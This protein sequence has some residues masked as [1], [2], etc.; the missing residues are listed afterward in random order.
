MTR[1]GKRFLQGVLAAVLI[2]AGGP[3]Q[4]ETHVD[5]AFRLHVSQNE[6][7]HLA[8]AFGEEISK[9]PLTGSY[10]G[11]VSDDLGFARVTAEDITYETTVTRIDSLISAAAPGTQESALATRVLL[12]TLQIN[13]GTLTLSDSGMVRCH[14]L[15]IR[16]ATPLHL[17]MNLRPAVDDHV[18]YMNPENITIDGGANQFQAAEPAA[19]QSPWGTSWLVQQIAPWIA[20]KLRAQLAVAVAGSVGQEIRRLT[21]LAGSSASLRYTTPWQTSQPV[22]VTSSHQVLPSTVT[23]VDKGSQQDRVLTVDFNSDI[24]VSTDHDMGHE[25]HSSEGEGN[26]PGGSVTWNGWIGTSTDLITAE[27]TEG[28]RA[29]LFNITLNKQSAPPLGQILTARELARFIPDAATRFQGDE[30]V[31]VRISQA[32][33]VSVIFKPNGPGGIPIIDA[34]LQKVPVEIKVAGVP[35]FSTSSTMRFSYAPAA[36]TADGQLVF[37]YTESDFTIETVRW[38]PDLVP[39]P[40]NRTVTGNGFNGWLAGC[41]DGSRAKKAR[42]FSIALPVIGIGSYRVHWLDAVSIRDGYL[43]VAAAVRSNR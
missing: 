8:N 3:A 38:N 17:S 5:R 19:C 39:P 25:I 13:I 37:H 12:G 27:L 4:A 28:V 18:L 26:R 33:D 1:P 10:G 9:E 2:A 15:Q 40:A 22:A 11:T 43:A 24:A 20:G 42:A 29:D 6:L 35:Y 14:D 7:K 30:D 34:V 31:E 36:D 32:A 21:E 41:T 23:L 16:A